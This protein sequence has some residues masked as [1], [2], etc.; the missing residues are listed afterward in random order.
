MAYQLICKKQNSL[1]RKFAVT[2]VEQV[3][4]RWTKKVYNH[5]VVFAFCAKPAN[6]RNADS[7]GKNLVDLGFIFQ[8]GV[9]SLDRFKFHSN[10]FA[11]DDVGGYKV[12]S[13]LVTTST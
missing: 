1:E 2:K 9:L 11:R 3:L 4:Q 10:F 13:I 6:K 8:L 7:T 12:V 5:T